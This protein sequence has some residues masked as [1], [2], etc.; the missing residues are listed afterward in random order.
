MSQVTLTLSVEPKTKEGLERLAKQHGYIRGSKPNMSGLVTAIAQGQLLLEPPEG[1]S[2]G[3]PT[4]IQAKLIEVLG[5]VDLFLGNQLAQW[6]LPLVSEIYQDR[7]E[8]VLRS[9]AQFERVLDCLSRQQPFKL[10]YQ[11]AAGMDYS[12]TV[13]F[14]QIANYEGYNYLECWCEET[15]GNRDIPEL[16]HNWSFRPDRIANAGIIPFLGAW[17]SGLDTVNAEFLLYGPLAHGYEALPGDTSEWIEADPPTRKIIRP[18]TSSFWFLRKILPYG[19]KCQVIG[20]ASLR[21]RV[22]DEIKGLRENYV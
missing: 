8:E 5:K 1:D 10:F 19:A 12:Y 7:I 21:E 18:I 9:A 3:I 17:R 4:D 14:A 15:A 11:D 22:I 20:N 2:Q 16:Q 6:L 13:R